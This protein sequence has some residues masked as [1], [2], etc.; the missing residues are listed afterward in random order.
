VDVFTI[1][2]AYPEAGFFDTTQGRASV[3][4]LVKFTIEVAN[5]E[6]E[7]AKAASISST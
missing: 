5:R 7:F 6:C 4:K 1:P 3:S 2:V